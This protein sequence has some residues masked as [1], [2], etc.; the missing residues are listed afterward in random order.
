[1][2]T[3]NPAIPL[4]DRDD[5]DELLAS[6][7]MGC[8]SGQALDLHHRGFCK[9]VLDDE[10]H[11]QDCQ[12][13]IDILATQLATELNDWQAGEAGSMRLQDGWRQYEAIRRLALHPAVLDLLR[14][15]YGREPFAFQT[16]N[17]AVGSEQPYHSDAAHFDSEPHGFMCGLWIPLAD[18][19]P[20]SGPLLYYPGSHRLPY[21]SAASLGLTPE[22]V[23]AEPHPQRFFEPSWRES[24]ER[25]D[26]QPEFFLPRRGEALIWHANLLHGGSPVLNRQSRRWSQVVHYFFADCRYTTP[27]RSFREDQGGLALRNPV[28]VAT[29]C[30]I[31]SPAQWSSLNLTSSSPCLQSQRK[32]WSKIMPKSSWL[33]RFR[34]QPRSRGTLLKGNLELI[35][36]ALVTGWVYHPNIALSE[37]RLMFGSRVIAVAMIDGA[38]PDVASSLGLAGRFG[39]QLEI[40]ATRP[41]LSADEAVA[42][43][44]ITA[45]GSRQFVLSLPGEA[46]VATEMRLRLALNP[47]QRGKRGHFDGLSPN[48]KELSGWCFSPSSRHASIWLHAGGLAPRRIICCQHR[49]GMSAQGYPEDCGFTLPLSEWPEASGRLVWSSYDEAG[50]L[51]IPP[52]NPLRLPEVNH[53][54]QVHQ[55]ATIAAHAAVSGSVPNLDV[56]ADSTASSQLEPIESLQ[57]SEDFQ[58]HWNDLAEFRSLLDQIELQVQQAEASIYEDTQCLLPAPPLAR[59]L[60][61]LFKL[62]R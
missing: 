39:F 45:D 47:E 52:L 30:T 28:N 9:L 31:W 23:A 1:M 56:L 44:A 26:L 61:A 55:S 8:W 4:I 6:G 35:S 16:L 62:W 17:F 24:I 41:E 53:P 42:V 15:V 7:R 10:A 51:R 59:R 14:H 48:G 46:A 38:R 34:S 60:S 21:L 18:V 3:E 54:L 2:T 33:R 58:A 50:E 27:L 11:Q 13:V 40:S 36:P 49:P 29:G 19:E 20:E 32:T 25:H 43:M 22:Q 37:V 57:A 5:F 12:L